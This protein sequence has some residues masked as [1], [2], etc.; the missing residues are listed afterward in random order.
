M[1][2]V[3]YSNSGFEP[4]Y[5]SY[6]I[7]NHIEYHLNNFPSLFVFPEHLRGTI[8]QQHNRCMEFYKSN[9]QRLERGVW[10]FVD[11]YKN[12]QSL[13]HL[14]NRVAC[15]EA[16][17]PDDMIV[18]GANLDRMFPITDSESLAFGFF[19]P[20]SELSKIKNIRKR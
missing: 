19:I 10:A 20:E 12:N 15:F 4:Q 9:R 3:R 13:N 14:K 11:G 6:H 8:L 5:Q 16:D 7:K 17:V 2:I 1:K 18:F